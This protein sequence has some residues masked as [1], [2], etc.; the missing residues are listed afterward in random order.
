MGEWNPLVSQ[1][2]PGR[3]SHEHEV[4]AAGATARLR[5]DVRYWDQGNGASFASGSDISVTLVTASS[6]S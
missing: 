1:M 4:L 5:A 6:W 3:S 2:D